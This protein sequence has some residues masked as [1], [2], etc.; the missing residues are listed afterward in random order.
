MLL[1]F[2]QSTNRI[3]GHNYDPE[4]AYAA[5][6]IASRPHRHEPWRKT[7][8]VPLWTLQLGISTGVLVLGMVKVVNDAVSA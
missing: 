6:A 7:V 8:L 5:H 4:V 3:L 2:R 1:P